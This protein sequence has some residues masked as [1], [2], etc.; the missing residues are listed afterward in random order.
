[1]PRL[2]PPLPVA[3]Q[4]TFMVALKGDV[5]G[6]ETLNTF[7]YNDGGHVL[8]PTTEAD[9]GAAWA[10]AILPDLLPCMTDDWTANYAEVTCLTT[11]S[12]LPVRT[13]LGVTGTRPVAHEPTTVSGVLRRQTAI[14]GQC[15]RG[16]VYLPA[17]PVSFVD[18]SALNA[19]GQAAYAV[20]IG[21]LA[22]GF[23]ALTI[24][25]VAG[26]VS[27]KGPGGP[28][29]L[30]FAPILHVSYDLVLGT[31]RRRRLGRGV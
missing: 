18:Q 14:R 24:T 17:V 6:Q 25:Y 11:P 29:Y 10:A 30:G 22:S 15:G 21:A 19:T 27:R 20:A 1:M 4:N 5:E 8:T 12:R 28:G 9:M 16:R 13:L 26:L 31:C 2:N 3:L 7:Y 23:T